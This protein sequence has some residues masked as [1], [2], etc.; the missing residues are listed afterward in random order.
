MKG[1]WST[2]DGWEAKGA[3]VEGV[4]YNVTYTNDQYPFFDPNGTM[5]Q[6]PFPAPSSEGHWMEG[7]QVYEHT[8]H[9]ED[10]A[11]TTRTYLNMNGTW[12]DVTGKIT[13]DKAQNGPSYSFTG[14]VADQRIFYQSGAVTSFSTSTGSNINDSNVKVYAGDSYG[15]TTT[16]NINTGADA[17]SNVFA[18]GE[19][20]LIVISGSWEVRQ[21]WV[22]VNGNGY[23]NP[24][25]VI[26]SGVIQTAAM[27]HSVVDMNPDLGNYTFL[28]TWSDATAIEQLT[29]THVGNSYIYN[30]VLSDNQLFQLDQ[31]GAEAFVAQGS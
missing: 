23:I 22:N 17:F 15:Y 9:T 12:T 26:Q 1:N 19:S 2:G 6:S 8:M 29:L 10:G 7:V 13:V 14:P 25:S 24:V 18:P 16:K 4:W 11:T 28:D 3:W 31:F 5:T 27:A 21:D 20:R 30:T